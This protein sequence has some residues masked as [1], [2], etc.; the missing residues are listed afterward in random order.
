MTDE[1]IT[2]C[3]Y[4]F[5]PTNLPY[6]HLLNGLIDGALEDGRSVEV[7]TY[8]KD[9]AAIGMLDERFAG[10]DITFH[11]IRKPFSNKAIAYLYFSIAC[12]FRLLLHARGLVVAPSTPPVFMGLAV[13]LAKK[14]SGS[15]FRFVYHVQ[16]IHPEISSI[17]LGG[18]LGLLGRL[19]LCLD[20]LA[21]RASDQI[22]TLSKDMA[23][24]L[25]SRCPDIVGQICIVNNFH[26][27]LSSPQEYGRD[28]AKVEISPDNVNFVYAGNVGRY[29]NVESMVLG[30]CGVEDERI[31]LFI[32]GEGDRLQA[33]KDIAVVNDRGRRVVFLGKVDSTTAQAIVSKCDYGIVSLLSRVLDYAYPSKII[34]Y[35]CGGIPILAVVDENSEVG[36][37]IRERKLGFAADP[38]DGKALVRAVK[39]ACQAKGLHNRE[40]ILEVGLELFDKDSAVRRFY[41]CVR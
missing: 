15:R 40:E 25:E 2:F 19:F 37:L 35:L 20:N 5:Y 1:R 31:R 39:S 36:A 32:L 7:I 21:L 10:S 30:F 26:T 13:A 4:E 6:C 9:T 33:A 24:S 17:A 11:L 34:S 23:T 12:F 41:D 16:D 27:E 29:Q 3:F 18:R 22:V 8:S 14:L 28:E 38:M